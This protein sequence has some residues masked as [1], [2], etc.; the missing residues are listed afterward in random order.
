MTAPITTYCLAALPA[1]HWAFSS[2]AK[3]NEWNARLF[4]RFNRSILRRLI[5]RT[6]KQ[7]ITITQYRAGSPI[8]FP[9]DIAETIVPHVC[10][11]PFTTIQVDASPR[12]DGVVVRTILTQQRLV[13]VA[14]RPMFRR[15]K[16]PSPQPIRRGNKSCDAANWNSDVND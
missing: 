15:V 5:R 9:P 10:Y 1:P 8:A 13:F 3:L 6:W 16:L 11:G 7:F 14:T 2:T 12:G 4:Q